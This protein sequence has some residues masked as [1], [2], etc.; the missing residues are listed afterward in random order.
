MSEWDGILESELWDPGA[1]VNPIELEHR[2]APLRFDP[3]TRP[4]DLTRLDGPAPMPRRSSGRAVALL[5]AA[6]VMLLMVQA[7]L[8]WRLAWPEGQGW[9][10]IAASAPV[11]GNLRPGESLQ[12]SDSQWALVKVARIGSMKILPHTEVSLRTTGAG[13]HRLALHRGALRLRVWSPPFSLYV[14]TPAG[15]VMDLGCEF[16]VNT[17][18]ARTDVEVISGWVQLENSHGEVLAPEGTRTVMIS[19][20]PPRV[21]VYADAS[22]IFTAAVRAAEEGD[23][24]AA[25]TIIR[26]ARSRD[27][28]T[29]LHLALRAES[30]RQPLIR[31]AHML[32]PKLADDELLDALAGDDEAVW[33]WMQKLPLPAPKGWLRNWRDALPLPKG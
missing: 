22:P 19:G 3:A 30:H 17:S 2:L 14:S 12:T 24:A 1:A 27:T 18:G 9:P 28:L 8:R 7:A 5:V 33:K 13:R 4:L 15:E 23:L 26:A 16:I 21:P 25:D 11:D 29:L 31:R 32:D 6:A 10:V 20:S